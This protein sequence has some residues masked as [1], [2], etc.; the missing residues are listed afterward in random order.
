[1]YWQNPIEKPTTVIN[2]VKALDF[3]LKKPVYALATFF[4]TIEPIE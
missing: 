1:M 2:E 4:K 3:H